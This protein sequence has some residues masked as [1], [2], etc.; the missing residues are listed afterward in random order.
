METTIF[1]RRDRRRLDRAADHYLHAC[2]RNRTAARVT[3]FAAVLELTQPYLSRFVA[4]VTGLP[5]RD[6]L[7]QRQL[8]YTEYLLQATP[9][10]VDKVAVAS[11]FGDSSTFYRCFKA[12]YGSTPSVYRSKIM[13]CD[14]AKTLAPVAGII[15]MRSEEIMKC[16]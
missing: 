13:K 7:R 12:A 14:D 6:Y 3:E 5:V 9:L 1:S 8:A 10:P 15:P 4:A 16:Q 2:Y 11:G